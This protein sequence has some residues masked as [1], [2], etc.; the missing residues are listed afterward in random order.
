[1]DGESARIEHLKMIQAVI[2]RMSN[3]SAAMKRHAIVIALAVFGAAHVADNAA[4]FPAGIVAVIFFAFIDAEYLRTE[5]G[6]RTL[7][8]R[9]RD[10]AAEVQVNFQ[11]EGEK[12]EHA[13]CQALFSWSVG[14]LYI[15]LVGLLAIGWIKQLIG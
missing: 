10:A 15:A 13:F 2:A 3:S 1:M 4:L 6:Y 7:Y 11:M 5:K 9:V 14:M 12:T 8:N